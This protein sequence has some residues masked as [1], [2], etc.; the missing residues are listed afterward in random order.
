M[1]HG[2]CLTGEF[3]P[4]RRRSNDSSS[5]DANGVYGEKNTRTDLVLLTCSIQ[6]KIQSSN[7]RLRISFTANILVAKLCCKFLEFCEVTLDFGRLVQDM[8]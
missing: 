8:N 5:A 4:T 1:R 7:F 2:K 3:G 6:V